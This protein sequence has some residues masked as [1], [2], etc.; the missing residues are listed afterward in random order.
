[1]RIALAGQRFPHDQLQIRRWRL[2]HS[3]IRFSEFTI[4][5]RMYD[6]INGMFRR[7]RRDQPAGVG[8][9][10]EHSHVDPWLALKGFGRERKCEGVV[11]FVFILGRGGVHYRAVDETDREESWE[12]EPLE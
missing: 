6:I 1:M 8:H 11:G 4:A 3:G 10:R 2:M 7:G 5:S 12:N 9:G